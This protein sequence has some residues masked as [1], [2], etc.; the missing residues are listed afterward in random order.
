M[1]VQASP[2]VSAAQVLDA[3]RRAEADGRVDYA[4]Q[5]YRHLADHHSGAPE[6]AAARD[7]LS[8]LKRRPSSPPEASNGSRAVNPPPLRKVGGLAGMARREQGVA[9]GPIR[10]A[11]AGTVQTALPLD[12]P[13]PVRGYLAGRL[14]AHG[15]A[16]MGVLLFL[17][18]LLTAVAG[19][20]L[21][22][23]LAAGF[24]D[25]MPTVHPLAAPVA[26]VAGVV[27]VFWGQLARAIFDIASASRDI[28]AINRA[29]AEHASTIG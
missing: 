6:A 14:I 12:V 18:G 23:D 15:F 13:E 3:G 17:A 4:I 25:W 10:I 29:K 5:F 2:Q 20:M 16:A 7:A 22:D 11:P 9:R 1:V 26:A 28:A 27:L 21:P 19:V 24:A 8:R